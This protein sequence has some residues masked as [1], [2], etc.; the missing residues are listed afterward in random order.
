MHIVIADSLPASAADALRAA[1]WSVDSKSGRKPD[2]LARDLGDA[3]ALIVRSA[4]QVTSALID[5]APKLRVIARA[6]TGVDNVDVAAAT[7]R[8]ILVMNAAG[9]NSISVAELAVGLMLALARAIPAA[10]ASM[11]QGVWDKKSFMG[12]ELRGQKLGV[13][14]F[15]RIGREVAARARAFGMEIVAYDPFIAARAA[16]AAGVPLAELDDLLARADFVTL[17]VPA[18]PETRH[19]INAA[20]L[21][22]MKK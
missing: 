3:D 6:G 21:A 8:G 4:T 13:I 9:A 2:E 17:H 11:K 15:G 16:E 19:L 20:R 1:G 14:G 7:A 22:K 18:L 10:D 5:S 12:T